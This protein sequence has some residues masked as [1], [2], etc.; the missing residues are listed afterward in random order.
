MPQV[1]DASLPAVRRVAVAVFL[2]GALLSGSAGPLTAGF[3]ARA[4]C[5]CPVPMHCCQ[6]D[7]CAMDGGPAHGAR[8][9][10]AS[11][12]RSS[13]DGFPAMALILAIV[14]ARFSLATSSNGSNASLFAFV[15]PP[16]ALLST[17]RPPP[18]SSVF[19]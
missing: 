19:S 16:D 9:L 10:L 2:L 11:C 8:T 5:H 12:E 15:R 13:R 1:R 18:R 6:S 4:A 7:M 17:D 3:A 14:P